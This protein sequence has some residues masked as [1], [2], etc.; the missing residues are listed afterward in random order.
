MCP[1][2]LIIKEETRVQTTIEINV[3]ESIL[4][5][6]KTKKQEFSQILCFYAALTLYR[7]NKLS[8]GKAAQLS[9]YSRVDFID[10][11]RLE[12]QPIFDYETELTEELVWISSIALILCLK[13]KDNAVNQPNL[14]KTT[15]T[16]SNAPTLKCL[17][18]C[19]SD[20]N[21]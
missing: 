16:H 13:N 15:W 14:E 19:F 1:T 12:E 2:D 18:G 5:S 20:V 11:L 21:I 10:K 4:L 7:K 3:D 9:G 6:L 17:P 8:L